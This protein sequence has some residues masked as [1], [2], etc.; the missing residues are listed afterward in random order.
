MD[1]KVSSRHLEVSPE[2]RDYVTD[3]LGRLERFFEGIEQG[4]V[5]FTEERNPRIAAKE[6]CE[7]TL[8]G[9]GHVVRAKVAASD[10]FAA[11]DLVVDKLEHQLHKLKTR[12]VDRHHGKVHSNGTATATEVA[13]R[14]VKTKEFEL[15]PMRPDE[16]VVHMELVEHEFFFFVNA[17]SGRHAVVYRRA[18]GDI[19]LIESV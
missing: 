7:A 2:L 1:I 6:I 16:A 9:H 19:G 10:R 13:P 12:V 11:V 14:V 17:E 3:K 5:R 8:A 4:E 15:A 18:D